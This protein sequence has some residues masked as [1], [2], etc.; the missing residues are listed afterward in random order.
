MRSASAWAIIAR[1]P[2]L[3]AGSPTASGRPALVTVPMPGPAR[4]ARPLP[5]PPRVTSA[6]TSAPWVT[7]GSSPA[8]FTIPARADVPA[9]SRSA[10][11]KDGRWPPGRRMVTGSGK[12]PVSS[13]SAAAR[14]AAAAQAPVVQPRLRGIEPARGMG[15]FY[16]TGAGMTTNRSGEAC[17]LP[18]GM[19]REPLLPQL[20]WPEFAAGSVWL[21]GAGPGD[22]GLLSLLAAH[23]L[24]HADAVVYDAL[25]D[26]RI[27]KLARPGATLDFAGNRGGRPS[28]AQ[29]D[30]SQ[31]LIALARAG[32]RVLRLKG[33]DPFVFG[34]G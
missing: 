15:R 2:G 25:V 4:K 6:M 24:A 30:I 3:I 34:R 10:S 1:G 9:A 7:S 5:A 23:A 18:P 16:G 33:G 14:A 32:Q 28:P 26:P 22:P 8:S 19:A 12:P 13:A 11:G 17:S 31:R 29:P 27:L 20:D 21:V